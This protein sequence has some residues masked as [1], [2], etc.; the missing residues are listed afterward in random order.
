MKQAQTKD[1]SAKDITTVINKKDIHSIVR[2]YNDAE[3]FDEY[4]RLWM[5]SYKLGEVPDF[6]IQL[7]FELN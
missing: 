1:Q 6:P 3:A 5:E 7:D 2:K 4:R